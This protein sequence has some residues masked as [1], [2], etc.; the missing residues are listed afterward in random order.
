MLNILYYYFLGRLDHL[1]K[2]TL[3][4]LKSAL[5]DAE[6]SDPFPE[7]QVDLIVEDDVA[8]L[9]KRKR[10]RE[11]HSSNS[12]NPEVVSTYS[13]VN[14][15]SSSSK[16][17]DYY[18]FNPMS[19]EDVGKHEQ[20]GYYESQIT[21]VQEDILEMN[22]FRS[23]YQPN[24]K[25]YTLVCPIGVA[26]YRDAVH[27]WKPIGGKQS[28]SRFRGLG[29]CEQ[30]DTSLVECHLLTGRTHQLRLH[31]QL[32]N[33]PIANDPCYG[34]TL[35]FDAPDRKMVALAL[36]REMRKAHQEPLSKIPKALLSELESTPACVEDFESLPRDPCDDTKDLDESRILEFEPAEPFF[37]RFSYLVFFYTA[38]LITNK[39]RFCN[40]KSSAKLERILHCDGIW[41]HAFRYQSPSFAFQTSPPIWAAPFCS[42]PS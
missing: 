15:S 21:D 27:G 17:K 7:D 4:D 31:L 13:N 6:L 20:V 19:I 12:G 24:S 25:S 9:N 18:I 40:S 2:L 3:S 10:K 34:G 23:L 30:D 1:R 39:C 22:S 11:S 29:Y 14:E 32:I 36:L 41:L 16:L 26:S 37:C 5:K 8:K 28:V 42:K 35:F 33:S 38:F